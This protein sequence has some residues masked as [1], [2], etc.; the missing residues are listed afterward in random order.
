[1]L[2]SAVSLAPIAGQRKAP[3]PAISRHKNVTA[4]AS[5]DPITRQSKPLGRQS[6]SS[7]AEALDGRGFGRIY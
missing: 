4:K 6:D 1:L 7:I 2:N 5:L 3:R